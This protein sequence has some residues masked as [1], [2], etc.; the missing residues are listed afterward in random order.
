MSPEHPSSRITGP[1]AAICTESELAFLT[2]TALLSSDA[3]STIKALPRCIITQYPIH[4][5]FT[6]HAI[7]WTLQQLQFGKRAAAEAVKSKVFTKA[8]IRQTS[9]ISGPLAG[10][11]SYDITI[12]GKKQSD[13]R[14][15]E[16]LA[17]DSEIFRGA[18]LPY[19]SRGCVQ[20]ERR[21]AEAKIGRSGS[22]GVVCIDSFIRAGKRP[23]PLAAAKTTPL[24]APPFPLL[25]IE[26]EAT[27]P[28]DLRW[29]RAG[30]CSWYELYRDGIDLS[31]PEYQIL[32]HHFGNS[33][34][35]RSGVTDVARRALTRACAGRY[36]SSSRSILAG[37]DREKQQPE[38]A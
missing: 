11:T 31:A 10:A 25:R 24:F 30:Q 18:L 33:T 17:I 3:I 7:R 28:A 23:D 36:R 9:W 29:A 6:E 8:R 22:T 4:S 37:F 27:S 15:E 20:K 32:S 13:T 35:A 26:V 34:L 1:S 12:K 38:K 14:T 19:T 16:V 5:R 21:T 2:P